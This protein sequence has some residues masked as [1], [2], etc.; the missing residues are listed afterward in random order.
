M[1]VAIRLPWKPSKQLIYNYLT[2]IP[3]K[4][5]K[6]K[7]KCHIGKSRSCTMVVG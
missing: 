5:N 3:W 1:Y 4:Y 2:T 6:N 7:I